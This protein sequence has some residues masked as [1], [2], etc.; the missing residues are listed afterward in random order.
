MRKSDVS[1]YIPPQDIQLEIAVLGALI[2]YSDS[3]EQVSNILRSEV[4]YKSDHAT[5]YKAIETLHKD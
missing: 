5:I 1:S 4:F 3:Y 2:L